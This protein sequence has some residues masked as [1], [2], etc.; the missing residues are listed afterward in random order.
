MRH[1][2]LIMALATGIAFANPIYVPL[3]ETRAGSRIDTIGRPDDFRADVR[4]VSGVSLRLVSANR[5]ITQ[6]NT[7][8]R[9]VPV[10]GE[11]IVVEVR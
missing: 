7:L 1:I 2:W 8:L 5:T 4:A 3:F 6:T 11:P 9:V 10:H